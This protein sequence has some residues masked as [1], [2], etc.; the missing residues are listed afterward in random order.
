MVRRVLRFA[1]YRVLTVVL[2]DDVG[3][4]LLLGGPAATRGHI[5]DPRCPYARAAPASR[6]LRLFATETALLDHAS[7]PVVADYPYG[8]PGAA[9][10]SCVSG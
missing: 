2:D 5:G 9:Q 3:T 10:R 8:G 7:V 4:A 1:L 6:A